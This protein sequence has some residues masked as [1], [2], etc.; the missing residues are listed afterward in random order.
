[1]NAFLSQTTTMSDLLNK[2]KN[3]VHSDKKESEKEFSVNPITDADQFTNAPKQQPTQGWTPG[4]G[5]SGN[6]MQSHEANPG[7]GNLGAAGQQPI[8]SKEESAAASAA[9]NEN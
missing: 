2:I 8:L 1:M 3:A 4:L 7:L 9:L 6:V 5:S